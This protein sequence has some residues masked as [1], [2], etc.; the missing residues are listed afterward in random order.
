[1]LDEVTGKDNKGWGANHADVILEKVCLLE[2][3]GKYGAAANLADGMMKKLLP[4]VSADPIVKE[5][6]LEFYYHVVY[7]FYKFGATTSDPAKKERAIRDAGGQLAALDKQMGGFG[8]DASAK[9]FEELLKAEPAL[10]AA[11]DQAKTPR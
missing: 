1:M 2:D 9:R 10:K 6:Y 4:K 5:K 7:S 11:Y 3:T 8:S